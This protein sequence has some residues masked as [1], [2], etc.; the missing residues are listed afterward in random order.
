[1]NECTEY[2]RSKI[3]GRL[4]PGSSNT[5]TGRNE[6]RAIWQQAQRTLVDGGLESESNPS[7]LRI[8]LIDEEECTLLIIATILVLINWEDWDRFAFLFVLDGDLPR[9]DLPLPA[10]VARKLLPKHGMLFEHH[11]SHF[12]APTI[13]EGD[14]VVLKPPYSLP[15]KEP[16]MPVEE[17]AYGCVTRMVI[18]EGYFRWKDPYGISRDVSQPLGSCDLRALFPLLKSDASKTSD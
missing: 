8:I 13:R 15:L 17:G 18:A 3:S 2:V 1:M 9:Y 10:G 7:I 14:N 11:Q 5:F 6:L 4:E 12:L 16:E